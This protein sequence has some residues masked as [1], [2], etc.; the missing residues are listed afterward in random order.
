MAALD[1]SG[2]ETLLPIFGFLLVFIIVYSVV[3]KTKIIW[4]S[5]FVQLLAAFIISIVFV[6]AVQP[7]EYIIGI[8]PW[9]AVLLVVSFLILAMTGFIGGLEPMAK[10]IGKGLVVLL[11]V[12]FLIL[13]YFVFSSIFQP[14]VSEVKDLSPKV[15]GA[16]VLLVISAVVSWVLVKSK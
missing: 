15:L 4:E 3:N 6:L 11:L 2:F 5:K 16:I 9:F 12:I 7:R 1:V 10:G 13:A 14:F 8:I